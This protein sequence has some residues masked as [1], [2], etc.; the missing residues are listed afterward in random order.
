MDEV[1]TFDSVKELI[2]SR[3]TVFKFR[4]EPVPRELLEEILSAGRWA[5]NH[6]LTEPWRF[7]IIGE[8]ARQI[9]AERYRQLQIEKATEGISDEAKRIIGQKGY[10]K[11]MGRPTAVAVSCTRQGDEQEQREDYAATCCAML[12][13]QLQG[14]AYGIGMQWSTGAITREPATYKLLGIDPEQEY[15]VGFY[16]MGYPTEVGS[17]RR[18]PLDESLRT[19]A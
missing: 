11:F 14:W 9:L 12:L 5:P 7:T 4:P 15:I 17:A 3:R 1:R 18:K 8:E 16:F 10:D 13:I 6:H 19:T 2:E